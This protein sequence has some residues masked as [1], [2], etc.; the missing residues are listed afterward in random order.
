[1]QTGDLPEWARAGFTGAWPHMVGS[2]GH[3]VAILFAYPLYSPP[4]AG[5]NNKIF[6]VERVPDFTAENLEIEAQLVGTVGSVHHQ[7]VD[8]PGRSIVDLPQAGCW[9]LTVKWGAT[10]IRSCSAT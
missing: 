3:I 7:V 8:G 6:W 10:P 5:W 2:Q 1:V 9:H 4:P